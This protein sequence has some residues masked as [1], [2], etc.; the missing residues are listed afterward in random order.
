MPAPKGTLGEGATIS[1]GALNLFGNRLTNGLLV[2]TSGGVVSYAT[3]PAADVAPARAR[4]V[5]EVE[6]LQVR[7][8]LSERSNV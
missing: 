8:N 1:G 4:D 3:S 6:T 5:A 2:V 7:R